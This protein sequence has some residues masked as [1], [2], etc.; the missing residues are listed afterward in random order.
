M[1]VISSCMMK[2]ILL[3]MDMKPILITYCSHE[4]LEVP[5]YVKFKET[6]KFAESYGSDRC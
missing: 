6:L 1:T 5:D 2:N 4:C 3:L